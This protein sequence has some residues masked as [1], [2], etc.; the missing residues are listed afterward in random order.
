MSSTVIPTL[1][2]EDAG[3]AIRFLVDAFGFTEHMVVEGDAGI[4]E[5]AQLMHGS[6]M[7]MLGSDRNEN[8]YGEHVRASGTTSIGLYVI[9]ADV[10]AHYQQARAAGA[11]IV[12]EPEEQDYGGSGYTAR[13]PEGNVWSFGDYDPWADHG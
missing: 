7:V 8:A 3:A 12:M 1:R 5:H 9:V 4:I 10:G 11:E 6:G 2:Y 13:D